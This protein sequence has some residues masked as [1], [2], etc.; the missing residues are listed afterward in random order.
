ME[1]SVMQHQAMNGARLVGLC[2]VL[3]LAVPIILEIDGAR[4]EQPPSPCHPNPTAAA[5]EASLPVPGAILNLAGPLKDRPAPLAH[6]PHNPT[7]HEAF[8]AARRA[9]H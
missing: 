3:A 7:P 6:S 1:K 2:S 8:C 4:A 9:C 5:D